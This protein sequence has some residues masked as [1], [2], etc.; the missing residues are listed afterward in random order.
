M[1]R[2]HCRAARKD[3]IANR[4]ALAAATLERT[5]LTEVVTRRVQRSVKPWYPVAATSLHRSM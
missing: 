1:K 4:A 2:V 3:T 5:A